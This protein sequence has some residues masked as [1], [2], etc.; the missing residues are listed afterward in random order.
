MDILLIDIQERLIAEVAALKYVDED[1]GQLDSSNFPFQWPCA[2]IDC[3]NA[4]YS[5]TGSN[6]QLGLVTI[7]LRVADIKLSNG[8]TSE[9][10]KNSSLSFYV[11]LKAIFKALQGWAAHDHYSRL[12]RVNE[13]RTK[14]DDG[15]REHEMY[16]TCQIKDTTAI[17]Q[18][19]TVKQTDFNVEIN[20]ELV[21]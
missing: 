12:I 8:S 5:N 15:V 17:P 6:M 9:E 21:E 14:R 18:K 11:L 16:F 2:L 7:R 20:S 3:F 13:K 4:D 19:L 1:W 10:Q